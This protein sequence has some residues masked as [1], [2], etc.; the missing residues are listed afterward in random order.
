MSPTQSLSRV[1]I[2]AK[3]APVSFT[4]NDLAAV[5]IGEAL[6]LWRHVRIS[7]GFAPTTPPLMF[8]NESNAKLAKDPTPTMGLSLSPARTSGIGNLCTHSTPECRKVCLFTAG[9]GRYHSVQEGRKVRARFMAQHPAAFHALLRRE[10]LA[11]LRRNKRN[12]VAHRLN[13]VTDIDWHNKHP[14][15][16]DIPHRA[17]FYTYTKDL[18]RMTTNTREDMTYSISERQ[19]TPDQ[20]AALL[21]DGHRL[22][23]VAD[24][25]TLP[26][27]WRGYPVVNGEKSDLRYRDPAPSLV[28]LRPKGKARE[29][30]PR[31]AGFVKPG[32][33]CRA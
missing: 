8:G 4:T 3:P 32:E 33:W 20:V 25:P 21:A 28:I 23:M 1:T 30:M 22:A 2:A 29:L 26:K 11:A 10:I 14:W 5:D 17:R 12:H 15:L 19:R 13:V 18:A 7:H 24:W 6:E 9:H 27:T 31:A 16:A